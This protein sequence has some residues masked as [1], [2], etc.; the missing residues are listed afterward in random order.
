M[1]AITTFYKR[2]KSKY[3]LGCSHQQFKLFQLQAE[4]QQEAQQKL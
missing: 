3:K 2:P 4:P 1:K